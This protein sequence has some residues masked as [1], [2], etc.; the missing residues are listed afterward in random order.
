MLKVFTG[1]AN[2]PLAEEICRQLKRPLGD[3]E[4]VDFADGETWVKI[5]EN[6]RGHDVFLIQST[7]SPARNVMELLIMLDAIRRASPRRIT[8]VMPYF[9]YARQDRK[10]QPRVPITAKL[11]ANLITTAGAERVLTMD[12]HSAQIQGFFDVP[13]DHLFAS[14][15]FVEYVK[16]TFR[17][18]VAVVAPDIG[19]V[20]MARAYATRLEAPLA[21]ID[22]RR[23]RRDDVEVMTVIGDVDGKNVVLFDDI[24]S[25]GGTLVKAARALKE[26]GAKEITACITHAVLSDT[27][28]ERLNKSD[29]SR[30]AVT[31]TILQDPEGVATRTSKIEIL[32]VAPILATAIHRIHHE[33]SLSSLFI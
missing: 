33:E 1:N 6:I 8:A 29:I 20:K 25:T 3:A 31:D 26:R 22:K 5:N 9:G 18:D 14:P 4:V 10:D 17:R 23:T 11:M 16:Q 12:L 7:S 13:F 19:S 2:R 27:V 30:L 15:V 32:S 21:L 24:I 28:Y